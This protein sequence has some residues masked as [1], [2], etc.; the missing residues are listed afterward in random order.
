MTLSDSQSNVD[1]PVPLPNGCIQVATNPARYMEQADYIEA[2]RY[3]ELFQE[4]FRMKYCDLARN[5]TT[6]MIT[7]MGGSH[8]TEFKFAFEKNTI[9]NHYCTFRIGNDDVNVYLAK[10]RSPS[11]IYDWFQQGLVTPPIHGECS[12][13]NK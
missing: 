4:S 8:R 6:G 5:P 13:T 7:V 3:Y 9:K 11:S 1:T 12:A 10:A 2:V